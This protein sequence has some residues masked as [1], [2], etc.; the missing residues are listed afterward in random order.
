MKKL[1][2]VGASGFGRELTQYIEDINF[3]GKEPEWKIIGFIDDNIHA[4]GDNN[5]EYKVIDTI[6]SH[7]PKEDTYYVCALAFPKVKEKIVNL[8][9]SRGAAFVSIIHPTARVSRY[10]S[11]GEGCIITPG[12]NVNIDAHIG[13]FVSVLASGVGHDAS[14]DDFST[15]SGHVCVNGHVKIGK[16][17][18]VG[19]GALLAPSVKVGDGATVGIG[20]VVISNVK[21]N[22]KVFGNPAKKLDI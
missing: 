16:G 19:C 18:Y 9:K 20:S 10:A 4:L 17:A 15:L 22:T 8:L 3:H 6:Q 14:V 12:S 7:T 1:I 21:A 2:I 13:D 11:I 5:H